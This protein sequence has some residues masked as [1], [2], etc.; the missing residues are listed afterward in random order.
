[1]SAEGQAIST[2]QMACEER[3]DFVNLL[4]GLSPEQWE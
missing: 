1:M 4:A 2:M 3:T